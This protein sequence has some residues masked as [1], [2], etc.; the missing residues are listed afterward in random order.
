M[1]RRLSLPQVS[2]EESVDALNRRI[3]LPHEARDFF[4]S[5][6]GNVL[7]GIGKIAETVIEVK[8]SIDSRAHGNLAQLACDFDFESHAGR[9]HVALHDQDSI[10]SGD[11]AAVG[12]TL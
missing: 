10:A 2:A 9:P 8:V 3:A 4:M 11:D 5:H 12:H 1:P 7:P 6:D